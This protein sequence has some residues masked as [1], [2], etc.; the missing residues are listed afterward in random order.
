MRIK[1]RFGFNTDNKSIIHFLNKHRLR[2]YNDGLITVFEM[3]E[4]DE[5]F[6][7]VC[8]FMT[9]HNVVDTQEAVFTQEEIESAQWMVVR[10]NWWSQY[11]QPQ[12]NME[13]MF[14]TYDATEYC[15]GNKPEYYCEKGLVQKSSFVIKKE[16]NWN[17]RNFMMLNW[18]S[19]ELFI[20]R[21]A[22]DI[23]NRS[24]LKGFAFYDVL[25]KSKE[26][27]EGVKQLYVECYLPYALSPDSVER[28]Y[29]CPK[30]DFIK[31]LPK[32]GAIRFRKDAFYG[33]QS[34]ILKTSEKFGEISCYSL[35]LIN[36]NFYDIITKARLDRGL[37]FEPIELV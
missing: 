7:L 27:L 35:I 6:H 10:S 33:V 12:N 31:Y 2:Y 24:N 9:C 37:V 4:D 36:H 28:K 29:V 8:D 13:Y 16:P 34:D 26:K 18:I 21:K 22:E 3:F 1:H 17:S 19:D 25:D 23:L 30:C 20:S 14:T 11:P 32:I 5:N 15:D